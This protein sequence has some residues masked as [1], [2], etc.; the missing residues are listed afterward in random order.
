VDRAEHIELGEARILIRGGPKRERGSPVNRKKKKIFLPARK[1]GIKSLPIEFK[2]RKRGGE[3]LP[4]R[5][6]ES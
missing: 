2:N 6:Q 4:R 3:Y 5:G 1:P